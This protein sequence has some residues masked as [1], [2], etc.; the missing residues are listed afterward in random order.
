MVKTWVV[1][2]AALLALTACASGDE[3][4]DTDTGSAS[5]NESSAAPSEEGAKAEILESGFGQGN[6]QYVWVTALV[7]N[8]DDHG[9]QTVTVNF[10][11]LDKA[12]EVVASTSQVS[13]FDAAGQTIAAG[14]QLDAGKRVQVAKVEATLLVED[15]GIF[16]ENEDVIESA[17]AKSITPMEY[18]PGQFETRFEIV[19]P[20]SE[21]LQDMLVQAV[22]W[23]ADGKI[24]GGGIDAPSLIPP[25]GKIVSQPYIIV[26]GKPQRCT[27]YTTYNL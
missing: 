25:S 26:S 20:T 16:D 10:N 8:N 21:P 9:G 18:A 23:G 19:N 14:T 17:D 1:G 11:A 6:D 15:D 5:E 4:V 13:H 12:G 24:N 7:K 27:A 3:T 22:C 2:S